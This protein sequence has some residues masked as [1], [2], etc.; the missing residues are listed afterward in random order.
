[1][2]A[3]R[4]ITTCTYKAGGH[5]GYAC[6]SISKQARRSPPLYFRSSFPSPPPVSLLSLLSRLCLPRT[7]RWI[8]DGGRLTSS[9]NKSR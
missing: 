8:D 4:A 6:K 7:H 2:K 9:T 3:A 5:G 1:M